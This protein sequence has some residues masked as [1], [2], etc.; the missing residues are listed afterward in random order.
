LCN[1]IGE[2]TFCF[3]VLGNSTQTLNNQL[4][5]LGASPSRIHHIPFIDAKVREEWLDW[6]ELTS[7]LKSE[8]GI[9]IGAAGCSIGH[10][11]AWRTFLQCD[12]DY[13]IVLEDDAFFTT[14]GKKYFHSVLVIVSQS[15]L[16]LI[17]LGDHI[18]FN[19]HVIFSNL[20]KLNIR[21]ILRLIIERKLLCYLPPKFAYKQ[22]PFSAHAYVIKRDLAEIALNE[23]N[24][25]LFPVDVLLNSISQVPR[26][27]AARVR[28]PM[29]VQANIRESHIKIRGR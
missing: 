29:I 7:N 28:T 18:E 14:Y 17:H 9:G 10:R 16:R 13:L 21:E 24:F 4:H 25:F 22:F 5:E 15:D 23:K 3:A 12:H 1:S 19:F 2:N 26:N 27:L 11:D 20:L 6:N 8:V